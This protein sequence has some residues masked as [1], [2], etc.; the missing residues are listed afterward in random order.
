MGPIKNIKDVQRLMGCLTAL[1]W[2]MSQVG[3]CELPLYK[4]L[5]KFDSFHW[6]EEAK[7]A[8]NELKALIH[9]PPVLTSLEPG[10]TLL[11]YAATTTH[12]ISTTLVVEWKE[13][14]HIY[15]IQR[16]V[17]YIRKVLSDC[18]SRYNHVQKMLY[19][20]LIMKRKLLH[21]FESHPVHVV[22]SH[23]LGEI[24]RN[25]LAMGRI[26]KWALELMRLNITYVP[27]TVMK[28]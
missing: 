16:L 18:K 26:A 8:L 23:G 3:E 21:Y 9:E 10:E 1:N 13:L 17:Y 6:I 25:Y 15:K 7:K 12:V 2:F 28:S 11:L 24:V 27:Q 5:K 20:I 4:L 14:K 19:A 22:T